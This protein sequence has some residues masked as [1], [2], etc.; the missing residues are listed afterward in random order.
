[1]AHVRPSRPDYGLGFQS[2][3][4][5]T[6]KGVPSWLGSGDVTRRWE[7]DPYF[8]MTRDVAPRLGCAPT[9]QKKK[10]CIYLFIYL[11]H[12]ET[13]MASM[14]SLSE[15]APAERDLPTFACHSSTETGA[16][17]DRYC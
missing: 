9:P 17:R 14:Y 5:K 7:Q 10:K 13:N 11:L 8:R 12:I 16:A 6:F 15:G 4:L 2:K 3:V 1:M